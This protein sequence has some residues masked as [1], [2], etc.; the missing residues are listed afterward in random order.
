[1]YKYDFWLKPIVKIAQAELCTPVR[2][3]KW[4]GLHYLSSCPMFTSSISM[5][6]HTP[7]TGEMDIVKDYIEETGA[8]SCFV[9]IGAH[10]GTYSLP[11]STLFTDVKSFEPC[12][13]NF[14]LLEKNVKIN[15]CTNVEVYNEA[16]SDANRSVR[17][18]KYDNHNSGQNQ[19]IDDPEGDIKTSTLD[20]HQ[21]ENVDYI[22]IDVE[23]RELD[24]LKGAEK[25]ISLYR[26]L[27]QF[28]VSSLLPEY[29]GGVQNVVDF[30]KKRGYVLH[31]EIHAD[32][33]FR[34]MRK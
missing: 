4:D 22:K 26:P 10:I 6:Q 20:S 29:G 16:L 2:V 9:D 33:F 30:L 19:I 13:Q 34:Y 3:P 1:M 8:N 12:K 18:H 21:F 24:V 23:G 17:L 5:G 31:E 15:D 28:E 25:T 27:V 14:Y 11:F 32:M 7:Y